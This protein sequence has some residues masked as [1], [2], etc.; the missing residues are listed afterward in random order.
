MPTVLRNGTNDDPRSKPDEASTNDNND[1]DGSDIND[2]EVDIDDE[3]TP[4]TK[5]YATAC[6]P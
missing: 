4:Y 1:D 3:K 6:L 5:Q 2:E